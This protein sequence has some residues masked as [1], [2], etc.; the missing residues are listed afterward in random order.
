MLKSHCML[1]CLLHQP[2]LRLVK[3]KFPVSQRP[4]YVCLL[5]QSLLLSHAQLVQLLLDGLSLSL[6]VLEVGSLQLS[7]GEK[8]GDLSGR[9]C[10]KVSQCKV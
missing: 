5:I 10:C 3:C 7:S 2:F 6:K 9:V 8:V 1:L 4:V